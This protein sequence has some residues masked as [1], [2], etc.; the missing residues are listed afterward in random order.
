MSPH[1]SEFRWVT[2]ETGKRD[3]DRAITY[4]TRDRLCVSYRVPTVNQRLKLNLWNA[5]RTNSTL[6][7]KTRGMNLPSE[8]EAKVADGSRALPNKSCAFGKFAWS[9]CGICGNVSPTRIIVGRPIIFH[10]STPNKTEISRASDLCRASPL[11]TYH[12]HNRYFTWCTWLI[13]LAHHFILQPEAD[14][15]TNGA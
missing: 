5:A 15:F 1:R 3:T 9:R 4:L 13:R 7:P 10:R 12:L 8:A 14:R 11:P 6:G 2:T